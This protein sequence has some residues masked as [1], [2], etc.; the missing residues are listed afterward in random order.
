MVHRDLKP[1]NLMIVPGASKGDTD[2]TLDATVKILDIGLGREMFAD[3]DSDEQTATQLTIEGAVVGTPDYMSPEQAKD[4]RS[5]D[6]RADVYSLGCVLYHCL[7]GRPPFTDSNIMTQMLKH[8]TEAPQPLASFIPDS[9]AALQAVLDRMMAKSPAERYSSPAEAAK[10]L[11]DFESTGTTAARV[12]VVPAYRKWLETE[13]VDTRGLAGTG[14][15]QSTGKSGTGSH[16]TA[17]VKPGTAAQPAMAAQKPKSA[18]VPRPTPP[19]ASPYSAPA[20]PQWGKPQP[21]LPLEEEVEVELVAMPA[22]GPRAEPLIE[23][24]PDERGLLELN[25]RDLIMLIGGG[26]GVIGAL[27]VGYGLARLLRGLKSSPA[28][29]STEEKKE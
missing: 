18:P 21:V 17:A 27:G 19:V 26:T 7:T 16:R 12:E 29:T 15:S 5:S 4:A 11:R 23:P 2:T 9:T 6:I 3:S 10:A 8:A 22:P 14:D 25:R 1:S 24:L 13:S 20:A 28:E